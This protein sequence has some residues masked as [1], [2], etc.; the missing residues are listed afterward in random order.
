ME[1]YLDTNHD[2]GVAAYEFRPD[3]ICVQFKDG[4]T[5]L[6]TN[7]SAGA[8]NIE[9]MKRLARAGDGL[10]SFINQF[11]KMKYASKGC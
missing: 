11:V 6:Y 8:A 9:Q 1:R 10:N 5:Y 4:A 7:A 2:S 3:G